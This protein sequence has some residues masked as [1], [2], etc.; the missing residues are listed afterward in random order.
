MKKL[1]ELPELLTLDGKP[2]TGEESLL[3]AGGACNSGCEGGCGSGC[4]PGQGTDSK[5][6]IAL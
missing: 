2:F 6:P 3:G 4:N 1:F 5:E